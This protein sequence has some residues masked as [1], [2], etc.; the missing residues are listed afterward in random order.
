VFLFE[1]Q[2][3][4]GRRFGRRKRLHRA[5]DVFAYDFI[6]GFLAFE[7]LVFGEVNFLA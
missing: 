5:D 1:K 4:R 7:F 3:V 2:P 6:E